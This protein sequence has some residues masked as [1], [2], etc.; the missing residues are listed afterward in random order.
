MIKYI[1]LLR[2]EDQYLQLTA[3]FGA[4]AYLKRL[5]TE[6]LWWAV[7]TTLL[8]CAAFI[9]NELVD[10]RDTDRFSWNKLHTHKEAFSPAVITLML[11][12]LSA[13]GLWIAWRL[14][15][16]IWWIAIYVL[17]IGYSLPPIR[18]KGRIG[19]DIA[20]QALAC[21]A[22]PFAALVWQQGELAGAV[23]FIVAF[24]LMT[25]CISYPYQLADF[26]ADLKA[27]LRG[28]HIVLGV[29]RSLQ[30]GAG[31]GALGFL[32]G[33]GGGW[34]RN[35]VWTIPL[36]CMTLWSLTQYRRWLMKP[37]QDVVTLQTYVWQIK[38]YT[39]LLVPYL[40]VWAWV[41]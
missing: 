37:H 9:V 11:F 21:W 4:A 32:L 10:R 1:R 23:W 27:G 19:A 2:I 25:Q 18:F 24:I 13:T 40:L 22:L 17:A 28:T 7:A 15:L 5:D 29:R 33:I 38:P 20:A 34:A 41:L 39:Q 3:V 31:A 30:I 35:E 8:S 16:W 26:V 14:G 6:I 36:F 12:L